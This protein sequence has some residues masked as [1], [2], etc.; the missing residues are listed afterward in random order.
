MKEHGDA[1]KAVG[2]LA[3]DHIEINRAALLKISELGDL[4]TVEPYFPTEAPSAERRRF[5]VIFHKTDVMRQRVN[6]DGAKTIQIKLL[7]DSPGRVSR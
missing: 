5:P 6:P 3:G 4:K 7:G 2:D 1:L